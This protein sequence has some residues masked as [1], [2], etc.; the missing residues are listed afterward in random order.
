MAFDW[1]KARTPC[2]RDLGWAL[3]SPPVIDA[4]PPLADTPWRPACDAGANDL[5]AH[6]DRHP[7]LLEQHLAQRHDRRLGAYFES[8][9]TF[10]LGQHPGYRLLAHNFVVSTNGTTLGALD[11]LFEDNNTGAIIHGEIAVKFYLHHRGIAG[12][13]EQCWIGPNPDD[14]LAAKLEHL[15][16]H[17]L[18]LSGTVEAHQHLRQAGLPLPDRRIAHIKGRLF[19]SLSAAV[20]VPAGINPD[21]LRGYWLHQHQ[22]QYLLNAHPQ[23]RWQ[24]LDKT[25]WFS[26]PDQRGIAGHQL[27]EKTTGL[28]HPAMARDL[29]AAAG[30]GFFF[31]MP[32]DWPGQPVVA[33]P[34]T[35]A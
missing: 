32:D 18:A 30:E 17:Q 21:C 3:F 23:G 22:L 31:I 27:R 13:A 8:L 11:L 24:L 28:K 16:S 9:W 2:V 26:P 1:Q 15:A 4:L 20:P 35:K 12:T 7:Q 14:S 29:A 6:L 19:S 25:Q 34:G 5:L 33:A 10:F